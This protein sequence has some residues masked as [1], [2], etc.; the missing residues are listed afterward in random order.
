M[1]IQLA[2][3]RR[4]AI[5]T[6]VVTRLAD[7]QQSIYFDGRLSGDV[8]V[9][10]AQLED[11][12]R[13]IHIDRSG[14]LDDDLFVR[15]YAPTLRLIVVGA[16]HVSQALIPIAKIVGF[17]PVIVDPRTAFATA[18]RFPSVRLLT[19]W[20]DVAI[21]EM[22]PDHRTAIVTLTHDPKLDD[23]A[24]KSSLETDAFFIGSLGSR[25]THAA[26]L[27]RLRA[28]GVDEDQLARIHAP[29]G[30]PIGSRRP[31]EI[32]VSIIG[33]IIQELSKGLRSSC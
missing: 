1:L 2:D 12:G 23:P 27:E 5:P 14:Q 10:D 7:G 4:N 31:P 6:A 20:P 29:V 8:V 19:S 24:L 13:R 28:D 25:K 26:R 32:A 3:L 9:D 30:L 15:V 11:I 16:V 17:D 33:E 21:E 18:E 22:A